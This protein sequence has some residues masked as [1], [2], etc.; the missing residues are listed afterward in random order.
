MIISVIIFLI[1]IVL[2]I[3]SLSDEEHTNWDD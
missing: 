2:I 3:Y 1:I